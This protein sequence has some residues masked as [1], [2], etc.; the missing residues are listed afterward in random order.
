[1]NPIEETIAQI[2][3]PDEA[4]Q[5]KVR[6]I[7]QENSDLA[8]SLGKL[9]AILLKY[10]GIIRNS[11]PCPPKKCTI[12]CCADHGVAAMGVS[13]YPPQTTLQ[14]TRNYLVSRGAAANALA[15]YAGSKLAVADLGISADAGH[16]PGLIPARIAA[17]TCNSAKGPAMTHEEALRSI[18]AGIQLAEKGIQQ[19]FRC[20]LP[21][22]MGIANTTSSAAIAAVCC[23]LTPEEAAG[24]G[25]N[26][27]DA[28]LQKKIAVIHQILQANQP[29]PADG[30][31]ILAKVGGFEFG[32][33][34]GII[35]GAAAH[36]ACVILDGFNTGAAALIAQRLCPRVTSYIIASHLAAEKAHRAVLAQLGLTAGMD[37]GLRLG[38]ACGSS[39]MAH[40]L[41]AAI[42]AYHEIQDGTI[43]P[44][45]DN[46]SHAAI[47]L[48]EQMPSDLRAL[49]DKTFGFYLDTI[50]S[51]HKTAMAACQKRIDN[52]AKPIYCL[53]CLE[54]IAAE[55][56]GI[57]DDERPAKKL[58]MGLI[59]F[60]PS[61]A[62][63]SRFR[64]LHAF[65]EH[66]N[67]ETVVL[68]HIR[69]TCTDSEAFEFGRI[70]GEEISLGCTCVG[71]ALMDENDTPCHTKAAQLKAALC[72]PDGSLRYP[73]EEFLSHV[74]DGLHHDAAAVLGAIFAV[75][76]SSSL[77]VIDNEAIEIIS[78]Y[79]EQ[80]YP[81]IRPFILHVQPAM[82]QLGITAS[83]IVA[84]LGL[85]IVQAALFMLNDMK[86]FAET[87]VSIADDGPGAGK[88]QA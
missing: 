48:D 53:G 63:P 1:M 77:A 18:A 6:H 23:K 35:L 2:T 10:V 68:A 73:A 46:T 58:A 34:C 50:P 67:A 15:N 78:R 71:I 39:I 80:L 21:G 45:T 25:T 56:A 3:W 24:R 57:L 31:D 82:L 81:D 75:A 88:Q 86:S 85:S 60:T 40:M 64:L 69:K 8:G 20:F 51:L 44:P 41:D 54:A 84:C 36:H 52:L 65:T 62:S 42:S 12:I 32:A 14:M 22:E 16:L 4:A 26:I 79:A 37:L 72:R 76:H 11:Q 49:S 70:Q 27:S 87:K 17:G 55:L 29:D 33:I 47:Y 38:E 59:A 9:S 5:A 66:I 13:A 83:G 19:G 28:R 74:P 43:Q 7:L 30:I 61:Q